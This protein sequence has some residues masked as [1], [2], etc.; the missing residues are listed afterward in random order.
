MDDVDDAE[1][2]P[3]QASSVR[4]EPAVTSKRSKSLVSKFNAS[5]SKTGA[6]EASRV[7]R[8]A[9]K[10]LKN[11][12]QACD[13]MMKNLELF[14]RALEVKQN[15][16]FRSVNENL[17]TFQDTTSSIFE[18]LQR[19]QKTLLKTLNSLVT[20][21]GSVAKF[22]SNNT[23]VSIDKFHNQVKQSSSVEEIVLESDE[24]ICIENQK[25]ILESLSLPKRDEQVSI[26]PKI[27]PKVKVEVVLSNDKANDV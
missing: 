27:E 12:V 21:L 25:S 8:T 6:K 1:Y 4:S 3:S 15:N 2:K 24:E 11:P 22:R 7:S 26:A 19:T 9:T 10:H 13:I 16:Q 17:G 5:A 18:K 23:S 20:E 14:Q